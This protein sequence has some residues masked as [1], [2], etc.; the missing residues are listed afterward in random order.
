MTEILPHSVDT[1]AIRRRISRDYIVRTAPP[2]LDV[3]AATELLDG[4]VGTMENADIVI[5]LRFVETWEPAAVEVFNGAARTVEAD[6]VSFTL[7]NPSPVCYEMLTS[8][9]L[10][11]LTIRRPRRQRPLRHSMRGQVEDV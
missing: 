7:S 2:V 9:P 10:D 8:Q 3:A 5:D 11:R 4:L 1:A 6:G